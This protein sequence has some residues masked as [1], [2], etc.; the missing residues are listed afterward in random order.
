METSSWFVFLEKKKKGPLMDVYMVRAQ[1]IHNARGLVW[2][3]L[4]D[5]D[6]KDKKA[7]K[8]YGGL[9]C[10]AEF[11][12]DEGTYPMFWDADREDFNII[13]LEMD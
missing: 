13:R 11:P 7:E 4:T 9:E 8:L 10:I 12:H 6:T 5:E 1:S 3:E 2:H